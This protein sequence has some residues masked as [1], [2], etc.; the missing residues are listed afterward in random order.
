VLLASQTVKVQVKVLV[1]ALQA[2]KALGALQK[3]D[4]EQLKGLLAT[5]AL[6][7]L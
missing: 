2:L 5:K 6:Q 3:V 1:K 7:T 4:L